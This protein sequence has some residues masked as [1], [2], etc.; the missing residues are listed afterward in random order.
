MAS[1]RR[2]TRKTSTGEA[3]KRAVAERDEALKFQTA[4]AEILASIRSSASDAKPVFNAIVRNVIRLFGTR[5][6]TVFLLKGDMLELAEVDMS[7]ANVGSAA[8]A[9]ARKRF[10]ESFP[11][12]IEPR[13]L[14]GK[15]IRTGKVQQLSPIIGNPRASER[16][17]ALAKAFAYNA[18]AV[19]PLVRDG[20]AIG[21]ISMAHPEARRFSGKELAVLRAFADQAVIAI[22]NARLFNET[23]EALERQTATAEI[24][25]AISSSPTDTQ[26][27]FDAIATC[28]LRLFDGM[29][30]A[31]MLVQ[32]NEIS[33]ASAAGDDEVRRKVESSFPI[34]LDRETVTGRTIVDCAAQ[35][36]PDMEAAEL[37]EPS[38]ALARQAGVRAIVSAPMLREAVAI[39][40]I[41]LSRR[42]A[43]GFSAK[44]VALLKTF[45]DQAVIAIENVRLFNETKEALDQQKASAEVLGAISGS[46]SDT[47]PVFDKILS[48]C[49][50]LFEGEL[51][52][53]TVAD[54][55]T[56]RLVAYHGPEGERL[57]K[58]YPLPLTRE[59]GTGWAIL[60]AAIAH[61]PD[62]EAD[63]VPPGVVAGCRTLGVRAIVFAPMLFEGKGIGAIWVARAHAG[64]FTDKQI[65]QLR[66]FA[67]Q[68]VIAIQNARLVN[69]TR[70]ALDQQKA[71]AEVLRVIS[72]SVAD[73][74]PVF[75]I[76]LRSCEQLFAGLNVGIN[77]VGEDG[78]VHI[79][80]YHGRGQEQLERHFPVPLDET[81]GSG[82]AIIRRAVMHYPDVEAPGVPDYAR[83][84]G[85]IAGNKSVIFA[86]MLWEEK[87]IGAIFVGR[88]FI[89]P[90]SEKEIAL[91]KT[92]ADQAVI[93]IQ[94]ARLFREIQ[95][96]SAQLEVA[97]KHKSDFLANMSHELR[98][99]LN[100]IIGFSEVLLEK[101]F[102]EVNE[103]QAEYLK[104]IHESGRHLLSLINDILDLSKIEAG[105]MELE[106]S[107]FDLPGAVSNAMTLVR[108]RAQRHCIALGLEMDPEVGAL[109]ADE[110]KVKQ[111]LLNLL[112]NA[113]KF[114]PDGGRVEVSAKAMNGKIEIAVR[115][116]GVGIAPEDHAAVF[117]EFKQVGRDPHAQGGGNGARPGADPAPGRAARRRDRTRERAG[118]GFHLH[119][120]VAAALAAICSRACAPS[121]APG[122]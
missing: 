22:E 89:G 6:A 86:P 103:K 52:G 95:E 98:T 45:A 1:S 23:K 10:R 37:P 5:Y 35:S 97:N 13:S 44:Q 114:T 68:A 21:A 18:M 100:A 96:K 50:R 113:V 70:E 31:V 102:G 110:R 106:L 34:P 33:L 51:V 64:A 112:S 87:A 59:S 119:G 32:G 74:E 90:F 42:Y 66:T 11:Q 39:G 9:E 99:P 19:T 91:L 81:S 67:D 118:Q 73:T 3:L 38:R 62:I 48:S 26:P 28:A 30:V 41:V 53:I 116:T 104:D 29:S 108:E 55:D 63:G 93:A 121:P 60:N 115:D 17:V 120:E 27:V 4:T 65:T 88:D 61:F 7:A 46:I 54:G 16:A 12:P 57:G 85:K 2:K 24:L 107:T 58:I 84:G 71:S 78:R 15:A 8:F 20:V 105:R 79:A 122:R 82:A 25:N 92:F 36:I 72:S 80:A 109:E 43:G 77:V 49:E 117:E 40:A 69:E 101:M 111:I 56:V 47:K 94:N 76:I 75:E 83:R 14:T